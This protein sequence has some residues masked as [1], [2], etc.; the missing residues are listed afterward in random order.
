MNKQITE[1]TRHLVS[2]PVVVGVDGSVAAWNALTWAAEV[3]VQRGRE[4]RIVHGLNL[5]G[6]REVVGRYDL[7]DP[8]VLDEIRTHGAILVERAAEQAR[9]AAPDMRVTTEVSGE[10]PAKMMVRHSADAYLVVLGGS[11]NSGM[12]SHVG[13]ILTAVT[14]H[15]SGPVVVVRHD[16]KS[17]H[18]AHP[19]GPVVVGVDG[20]P[21][22]HA[23]LAAAF[24]EATERGA[25]LV[26]VHVANDFDIDLELSDIL[27]GNV[28]KIEAEESLALAESLAGWQEKYPDVQ[29]VREVYLSDPAG[30][31]RRW[32]HDAQLL[33]VGSRGRGGFRSLLLGSTSGSL[34]Q[35]ADCP[36]MVV[37]PAAPHSVGS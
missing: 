32:S 35:H 28:P 21:L 26:A 23:T 7:G 5:E 31:L 8:P 36:V 30:V 2:A 6:M 11:G 15:A 22:S 1:D 10:H 24:E 25:D 13:S 19:G 16:P 3:A 9:A 29:V 33:V 17:A 12:L 14:S 20:G 37:H 27:L 18:A 34:V 4:L